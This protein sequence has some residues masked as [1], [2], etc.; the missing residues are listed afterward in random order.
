MAPFKL[1]FRMGSSRSTSQE[2]DPDPQVNEA[3]LGAQSQQQN[4]QPLQEAV[5][6]SSSSSLDLADSSSLGQLS[7][8][9]KLLLP[10]TTSSSTMR[11]GKDDTV[12]SCTQ[13]NPEWVSRTK[14][15]SFK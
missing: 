10:P 3:L 8:E 11:L 14:Q 7:S 12:A 4:G 2:H 5:E 13:S 1:K 9:R 15:S 6:A